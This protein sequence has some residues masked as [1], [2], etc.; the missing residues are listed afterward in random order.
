MEECLSAEGALPAAGQILLVPL[1][2]VLDLTRKDFHYEQ[3]FRFWLA[4]FLT[5]TI[6]AE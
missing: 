4:G 5:W 2:E 1:V 6:N 3:I